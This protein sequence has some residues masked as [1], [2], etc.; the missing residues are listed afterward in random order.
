MSEKINFPPDV[1]LPAH[2]V[3]EA[4]TRLE[5]EHSYGYPEFWD[6][7]KDALNWCDECGRP[8]D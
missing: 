3:Q 2:A 4:L 5:E 1:L 6:Y 7:L 8:C